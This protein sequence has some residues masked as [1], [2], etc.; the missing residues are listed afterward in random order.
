MRAFVIPLL[1]LSCVTP[2]VASTP[3][4]SSAIW[5]EDSNDNRIQVFKSQTEGSGVFAFK[6]IAEVDEPIAKVAAVLI[7]IKNQPSWMP[8]VETAREVQK[9]SPT[10]RLSHYHISTPFIIKD[11]DFALRSKAEF[12]EK[13]SKLVFYFSSTDD[14]RI[15]ATDAVRGQIH[16]SNYTLWPIDNG[17]RTKLVFI[18]HVDPMGS[19]PKWIVNLFQTGFPRRVIERLRKQAAK[20][21]IVEHPL[22]KDLYTGRIKDINSIQ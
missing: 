5:E 14:P 16:A 8:D 9:L 21:T 6:A 2:V 18:V 13:E 19:V 11:R 20:P 7:D 17:K 15:P 4:Y 10:E 12:L 1:V 22:V 3:N